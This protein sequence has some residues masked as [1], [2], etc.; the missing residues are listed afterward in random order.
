MSLLGCGRIVEN[1]YWEDIGP[2]SKAALPL[3]KSRALGVFVCWMSSCIAQVPYT[4]SVESVSF[5]R[6]DNWGKLFFDAL[7]HSRCACQSIPNYITQPSI[8]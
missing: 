1:D 3:P 7:V 2:P 6:P 8:V 4:I 5:Q